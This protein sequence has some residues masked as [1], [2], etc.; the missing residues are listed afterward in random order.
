M[1]CL[2]YKRSLLSVNK[3]SYERVFLLRIEL[4]KKVKNTFE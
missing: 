1:D 4:D 3:F 2:S